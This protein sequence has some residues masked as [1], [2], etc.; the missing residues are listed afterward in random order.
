MEERA[1]SGVIAPAFY[2][3]HRQLREEDITHYWLAGGRG[4]GKSS[5]VSVEILLGLMRHPEAHAA[6]FRKV[7]A[8]VRESVTEQLLWAA[9]ALGV[10]ELWEVK[11]SPAT[12]IYRPTSQRIFL[13]GADDPRKLKSMR[14]EKGYIRY[15][16]Y[17]EADEFSGAKELRSI[18]QSLMRGGERFAVFYTFNPPRSA[19]HWINRELS[20]AGLRG[21]SAVHRSDY[22]GMPRAWLGETFLAEAER[23]KEEQPLAYAHEYLGEAVGTGGE[24]FPNVTLRKIEDA[25]IRSFCRVRRGIDWGYGADPFVYLAAEYRPRKRELLVYHEFWKRRA[26]YDEIAARIREENPLR[27]AVCADSAEPRSNSE[28]KARG[29]RVLPAKKGPGSVQHGIGWL[30]NLAAIVIDP[31]RCPNAAREFGEYSLTPDG[32]GGFLAGFPDRDNHCID[33][34]RYACEREMRGAGVSFF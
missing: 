12:L 3:L 4:S 21:D 32:N 10:R 6:V 15:L 31:V 16:W 5:A 19:A 17:E 27:E 2:E 34:L 11:F 20:R 22:R 13:R 1:V 25:E 33:A 18:N 26:G 28:L 24:V 30:Q 8:T 7:G 23:L 14:P 9:N 29:I